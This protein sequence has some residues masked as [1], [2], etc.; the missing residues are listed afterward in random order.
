MMLRGGRGR[1]GKKE[2]SKCEFLG[3]T[4]EGVEEFLEI[5]MEWTTVS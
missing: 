4:T 1:E 5:L 2:R 3:V